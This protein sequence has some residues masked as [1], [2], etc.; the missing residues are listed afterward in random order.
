LKQKDRSIYRVPHM[1][2]DE[3]DWLPFGSCQHRC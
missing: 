3:P 1:R 2:G